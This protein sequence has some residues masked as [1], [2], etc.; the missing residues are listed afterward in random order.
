MFAL[1]DGAVSLAR[2]AQTEH[3]AFRYGD[4]AYGLLCH[5]EGTPKTVAWMTTAFQDELAE[6]GLDAGAHRLWPVGRVGRSFRTSWGV[7]QSAM[8]ACWVA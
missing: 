8:S 1:P 6:E 2:S 4:N 3:Q 5:L 7:N